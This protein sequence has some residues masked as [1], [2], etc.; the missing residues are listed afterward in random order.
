MGCAP[1]GD[2]VPVAVGDDG[3]VM[4]EEFAL[5][6]NVPNPFNPATT[7]DYYVPQASRVTVQIFNVKGQL[8]RTLVDSPMG[9]GPRSATWDGRNNTG[10]QVAT[11][12]Y[13]YR[14]AARGI[15]ETRKMV[16]L[17]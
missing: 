5:Q 2:S 6:Q 12:V 15:S 16:L 1:Q 13:F 4:P 10:Q 3:V 14:L 17:R 7:I 11:G 8:V 9:A